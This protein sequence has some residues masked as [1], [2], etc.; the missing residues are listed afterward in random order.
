MSQPAAP[1]SIWRLLLR[2]ARWADAPAIL[3]GKAVSW[4]FL[5]LIAIIVVDAI[6][7]KFLRRLDFVVANDLHGF[8]NSPVFQDAEWHLHTIIFMG[9][10]GFA[11]TRNAHV[12]LDLF[13]GRLGVRGR[14]IVE[15]AGGVLLLTPFLAI[16]CYY[17]WDFFYLA[18]EKN[19]GSPVVIGI[20]AR[21][22]IKFFI[23]LGPALLLLSAIAMMLRVVVRLFGPSALTDATGTGP[24]ADAGYSAYT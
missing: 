24:I 5:P 22:F 19:E 17:G 16:F 11:Y 21:W 14:L 6:S 2:L 9:A 1:R 8:F 23:F 12:R 18:W 4:L 15:L 13:R 3:T 10:I 20:G 7:R